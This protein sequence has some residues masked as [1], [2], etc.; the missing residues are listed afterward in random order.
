MKKSQ[1][2]SKNT[3]HLFDPN[4]YIVNG[5]SKSDVLQIKDAFDL[6]VTSGTGKIDANCKKNIN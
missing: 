3:T 1:Q 2:I 4:T 5:L 6:L